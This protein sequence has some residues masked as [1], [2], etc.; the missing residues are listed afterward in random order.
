M[1]VA[2]SLKIGL[3]VT[4]STEAPACALAWTGMD[5]NIRASRAE[6]DVRRRNPG[7]MMLPVFE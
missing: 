3:G 2:T 5:I 1:F 7:F 4:A 6:N